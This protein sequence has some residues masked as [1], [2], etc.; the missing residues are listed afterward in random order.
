[1]SFCLVSRIIRRKRL[2]DFGESNG[3]TI[4]PDI[5]VAKNHLLA[6]TL[7]ANYE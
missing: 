5:R 7:V 4:D 3:S 1:M 2:S 6:T